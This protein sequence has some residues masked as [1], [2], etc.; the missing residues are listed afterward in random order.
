M[1][2]LIE[3]IEVIGLMACAT[4][5]SLYGIYQI[6]LSKKRKKR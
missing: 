3:F 4:G 5:V 6:N 2:S 1:I